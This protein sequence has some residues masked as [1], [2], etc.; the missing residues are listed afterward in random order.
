MAERRGMEIC[1]KAM[2]G[3]VQKKAH[4]TITAHSEA[5]HE[6]VHFSCTIVTDQVGFAHVYFKALL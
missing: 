5:G 1:P 4:V 6:F 2:R 3:E